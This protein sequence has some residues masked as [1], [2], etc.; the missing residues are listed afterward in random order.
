MKKLLSFAAP[1]FL[2]GLLAR[3]DIV[4]EQKIESQMING[5]IT[6]KIKDDQVR[7]DSPNPLGGT[8][9]TI[10][11]NKTGAMTSLMHAQKMAMKMNVA[12]LKQQAEAAQKSLNID[13]SKME[14][15]KATG[16]TEKVGEWNTEVYEMN[17]GGMAN[18]LWVAKDFPNYKAINEKMTALSNQMAGGMIDPGKFD[19]GGMVVK[20][21]TTTPIGKLTTTLVSAKEQPVEAS[22]FAIPQDYK[23]MQMPQLPS[24]A[25]PAV[26]AAPAAK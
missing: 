2:T 8:Q 10:I 26:P 12:T 19:L 18:R 25:A 13:P 16:T 11:D 20:S 21:E 5:S 4:L 15:P 23:E 22:E 9:T 6:T 1:L 3:A 17:V 24:G 7:I 14:K